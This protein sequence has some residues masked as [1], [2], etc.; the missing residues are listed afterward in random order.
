MNFFAWHYR[1]AVP[2]FLS[3]WRYCILWVS[4]Y[5][6]LFLL[7]KSLFAPWKRMTAEGKTGF[8]L[9][10]FFQ[11]LTFN[12][13]SRGIGATVRLFLFFWGCLL[14]LM[15]AL[16]G[17]P[18]L[19]FWLILPFV[20]LPLYWHFLNLPENRVKQLLARVNSNP[21]GG[22]SLI[23]ENEAGA[24]LMSH[25]GFSLADL[26]TIN[27]NPGFVFPA[28]IS[29]Y[30]DLLKHL[31]QNYPQ[32]SVNLKEKGISAT[33]LFLAADSWSQRAN[34]ANLLAKG[35]DH[36][37]RPG[38]GSQLLFGYTPQL[39][40]FVTDLGVSQPFAH[41]LIGRE[42]I[43]S[44]IERTLT[45]GKSVYLTG[46]PGVG[47]KTVVLEFARRALEGELGSKMSYQRILEFDY[48]VLLS[49]ATDLN[50]KKNK[51][52]ELLDEASRAGNVILVIRDLQRLITPEVEGHDFTDIFE[53]YLD[54]G[55]LRVLAIVSAVEFE[56]FVAPNARL[57]KHFEPVEVVEPTADEAMLI[58][59][60]AAQTLEKQKQLTILIPVLRQIL[61]ASD[62]YLTETPFPEKALELLDEVITYRQAKG[63]SSI[64]ADDV[65][66]VMAEKTGISFTRLTEGEKDK[67]GNLETIIHQKLVNQE[68][69]VSLIAKSIRSRSSGTRNDQRPIGSFMFLGPTGVGKTQTAKVLSE[70]YYGSQAGI[71][72]FNMA[73]YA[74]REGLVRLIGSVDNNQPGSMTT[75]IKN[76]PAS[77]L[78]LDEI[79]KSPP[80][81][82]N[83]F[84]ALLDEGKINDAFGKEI[85][86]RHLFV[87][88]TTNAGAEFIRQQV[89]AGVKGEQLQQAVLNYVQ[90][91]GLFSPEFL[92]RFDGTVVFE[93]LQQQ[94]LVDIAKL[95]LTELQQN[96]E[97]KNIKL[98]LSAELYQKVAQDGFDPAFG[99]R[100]MRRVI[101]LVLGDV[102]GKALLA[103]SIREGDS[104]TIIPGSAKEE[105]RLV[106]IQP[107]P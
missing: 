48:N 69:A 32:I 1:Q 25:V 106:K 19:F 76:R 94:N 72:R 77:L 50:Q 97:K 61:I 11:K 41:H 89:L 84:L 35:S 85:N 13:I 79:E 33:D 43:V 80:E 58:L 28:T 29:S 54:G 30:S 81:V 96:L 95:M 24:Y 45:A 31:L 6:S 7:L 65:N 86:C 87:I 20:S 38:I 17:L 78:L 104:I 67:L 57:R 59:V 103:G 70:V 71:L 37:G 21:A 39:D 5:F 66:A 75:A 27:L 49:G 44:R 99:A 52:A 3:R 23:F 101:D 40:K 93:P 53:K 98:Q 12:L 36:F 2:F 14:L 107:S 68:T 88:A 16:L 91:K 9:G 26:G 102:I 51:L 42:Q 46:Q 55:R 15:V 18:I 62:R 60:T 92:N 47:K 63:G 83:L 90:E 105:Y 82:Y 34:S 10:N 4:H 73:E 56:R 64:V 100:P 22:L 74:G 8:N